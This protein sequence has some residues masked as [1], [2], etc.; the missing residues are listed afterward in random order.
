MLAA[1]LTSE[2]ASHWIAAGGSAAVLIVLIR[3]IG[4][5]LRTLLPTHALNRHFRILLQ[6]TLNVSGPDSYIV[7]RSGPNEW[8][9]EIRPLRVDEAQSTGDVILHPNGLAP[10]HREK[11]GGQIPAA[12]A[13]DRSSG[14]GSSAVA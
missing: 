5:C 8:S 7:V 1:S 12:A 10:S 13:V 6:A 3:E 14:P 4:R 11:A 9:I 2:A